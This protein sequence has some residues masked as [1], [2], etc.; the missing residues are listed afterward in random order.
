MDDY[1]NFI[2]A[3]DPERY[4]KAET[5]DLSQQLSIKKKLQCKPFSYFMEKVAPDMLE[6]YPVV[7]PPPFAKGAVSLQKSSGIFNKEN[8]Q[9]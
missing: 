7:D 8:I 2:Y 1:K 4:E 3:R 9:L 5:G 6:Y